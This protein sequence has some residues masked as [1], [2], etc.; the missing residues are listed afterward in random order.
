[1]K[2]GIVGNGKIV[3]DM[4]EAL[5]YIE[6]E[7]ISAVAICARPQ[8]KDKA[9]QIADKY[10]I[11]QVYTD[12]QKMLK[13]PEI[14]FIYIALPNLLHY[15]YCKLALEKGKHLICEKPF[16]NNVAELRELQSLAKARKLFLFEAIT[17]IH[18]PNFQYLRELIAT[19]GTIKYLQLNFSQY[20]SR[21]DQYLNG[22]ITPVFNPQLAGGALRDLNIYN[23]HY[24]VGLLGK[25]QHIHYCSNYG[26][27]GIDTSGTLLLNYPHCTAVANAAKDCDGPSGVIIQGEKGYISV[28][29]TPNFIRQITINYRDAVAPLIVSRE[30]YEHRMIDEFL[31]FADIYKRQ[32]YHKMEELLD[33]S[34]QVMEVL[35]Q[36]IQAE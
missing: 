5:H 7:A 17:V 31:A 6:P 10:K 25:P 32:D 23:L 27:N 8:S 16:T 36:A 28:P 20:S 9:Q 33:H 12:Y 19:L 4:L 1:M 29:G 18:S 3:I 30:Q 13:N 34:I 14:D 2:I 15:E 26:T 22:E 11:P 21:Y 24:I 35:E